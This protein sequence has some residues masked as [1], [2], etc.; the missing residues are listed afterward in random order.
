LRIE[1]DP[2]ER[3][4]VVCA[5]ARVHDQDSPVAFDRDPTGII[6]SRARERAELGEDLPNTGLG[7][8]MEESTEAPPALKSA[9]RMSPA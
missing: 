3:A 5:S 8:D 9:T 2:E 7:Q 4:T 1:P 6:A